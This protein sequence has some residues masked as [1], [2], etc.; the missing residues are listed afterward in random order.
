M[1]TMLNDIRKMRILAMARNGGFSVR[2][3]AD[4]VYGISITE[5]SEEAIALRHSIRAFLKRSDVKLRD[6]RNC[7]SILSKHHAKTVIETIN[8]SRKAKR[9]RRKTA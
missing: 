7:N 6:W 3:I 5:E 8:E 2:G 9:W 1:K 4:R